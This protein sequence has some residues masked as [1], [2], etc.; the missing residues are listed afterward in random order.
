MPR[1]ASPDTGLAR[2]AEVPRGCGAGSYPLSPPFGISCRQY[3]RH[4]GTPAG[5]GRKMHPRRTLLAALLPSFF[6]LSAPAPQPAMLDPVLVTATRQATRASD[7]L[8]DVSVIDREAIEKAGPNSTVAEL[9]A[10][11]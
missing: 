11:Q 2:Q 1:L 7:L 6:S 8:S 5:K 9:L 3:L 10:Q 4:A